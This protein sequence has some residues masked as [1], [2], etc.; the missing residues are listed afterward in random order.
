MTGEIKRTNT[1]FKKPRNM[2]EEELLAHKRE[3]Y[4]RCYHNNKEKRMKQSLQYFKKKYHSDESYNF[5]HKQL[6]YM[7]YHGLSKDEIDEI[8]NIEFGSFE[9]F[10]TYMD[11]KKFMKQSNKLNLERYN[12][13]LNTFKSQIDI[14]V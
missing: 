12:E 7:N 5:K 1:P 2:T 10:K 9:E 14:V 3:I 6:A 4:R 8:K 13:L 11:F